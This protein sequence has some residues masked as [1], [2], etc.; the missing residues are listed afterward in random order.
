MN[1]CCVVGLGYIGLPTAIILANKG[2]HVSGFDINPEI[3]SKVNKG[4]SH[5]F[6]PN[7]KVALKKAINSGNFFANIIPSKADF[8]IIAVPTPLKK[9]GQSIPEA[10]IDLVLK[11]IRSIA[12]YLEKGNS[13]ILESTS[14]VGT[15]KVIA[16]LIFDITGFDDKEIMFAYCPE[17]VLPGNIMQE[18]IFNDRIIGGL[19]NQSSIKCLQ[20]YKKF[21]KGKIHITDS[22][23]AE[24]AKLSENAYRDLNIAFAN[25]ISMVCDTL[26]INDK[27]LIKLTN[28]HPRVNILNPSCGVGGHCIAV[29]PWF[30]ASAAPHITPLIQT[31]RKVN[32]FKTEWV[33]NKIINLINEYKNEKKLSPQLGIFGFT[34]KPDSDDTRESP[35]LFIIKK[36]LKKNFKIKVCEPNLEYYEGIQLISH[37]EAL[38]S[39]ILIFLV[40]HRS[41]KNLIIENKFILDFC[42]I[43]NHK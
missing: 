4:E 38:K 8:F 5:I 21:C 36:L 41:F 33:F 31:S 27:E 6:E 7:L 37:E 42:G 25:E 43:I 29:D 9:N 24:L 40:S 16:R 30:I 10:N 12:P 18:L 19:N 1:K 34:F 20:L 22:K 32:L 28:Y 17:R 15:T 2:I 26:G 14:P 11:S 35:A 23:T 3:V 39:D 13:I